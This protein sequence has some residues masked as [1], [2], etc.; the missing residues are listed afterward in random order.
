MKFRLILILLS[1]LFIASCAKDV[2]EDLNPDCMTEDMSY[3]DDIVPILRNNCYGCHNSD[4][5]Q[6]GIAFDTYEG[7]KSVVDKNRLIGAISRQP[8]FAPMPANSPKLPDCAIDQITAWVGDG[9]PNN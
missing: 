3:A 9:A 7:L 4:A 8:G 2:D 6:G 1:S 5:R